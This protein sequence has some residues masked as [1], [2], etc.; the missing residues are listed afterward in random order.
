MKYFILFLLLI[1]TAVASHPDDDDFQSF[2]ID[3]D[4]RYT[5]SQW[6]LNGRVVVRQVAHDWS[7][8]KSDGLRQCHA[9]YS[10]Y[11]T[12]A[13]GTSF[14]S[15]FNIHYDMDIAKGNFKK[16]DLFFGGSYDSRIIIGDA[17]RKY[18]VLNVDTNGNLYTERY[19]FSEN[20]VQTCEPLQ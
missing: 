5:G 11:T 3:G 2:Y 20:E 15:R 13:N 10:L 4:N 1:S 9:H 7:H 8:V 17:N 19:N 14:D 16:I 12:K 6:Y 18:W